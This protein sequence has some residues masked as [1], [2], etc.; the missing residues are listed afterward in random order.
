MH[1]T[2]AQNS[3][4]QLVGLILIDN[5]LKYNELSKNRLLSNNKSYLSFIFHYWLQIKEEFV[6]RELKSTKNRVGI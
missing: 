1:V 3:V 6:Q 4:T 2:L 5:P